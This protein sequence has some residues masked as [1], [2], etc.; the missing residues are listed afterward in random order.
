MI[1]LLLTILDFGLI[2]FTMYAAYESRVENEQ[3]AVTLFLLATAFHTALMYIILYLPRLKVIPLTYFGVAGLIGVLF[4][5]PRRPNAVALN[6]IRGYVLSDTSRPDER[7]TITNRY[8]LMEG[9]P[10]YE[11]YYAR[12]PELEE[13]DKTHRKLNRI[14]GNID[15]GYRPN[16]AMIDA[17]FSIPRH[18]KSIAFNEPSKDPYDISPEKA[19]MIAKNLARHLGAKVVGVCRVDPLCVYTNQRTDWSKTWITDGIEKD[20]PPYAF[21]IATEMSYTHVH[22]GPHTP[23]A[24]ETGN[25]YA[26]G[27]Y[28]STVMA[29]WFS[30]MG[31][32]GIAEHTG[33]YDVVLPPLAVQAGMGE[34]GRN[35]FLITSTLGSRVRLSAVMT[36]MP[37][38][39]DHPIDIAVE[40]FCENCKKCAHTCPSNSIPT[41]EKTE[42]NGTLRWKV[43]AESCSAYWNKVGTDCAICMAICPY[44][45]PDTLLHG[46]IR[47]LVNYSW[48]A[49]KVFPMI[50]DVLYGK[51]WKVKP[52]PEWLDWK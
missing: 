25:Q 10:K 31:Y 11:E 47:R 39:V 34:I 4:L 38:K 3:R 1:A 35:G 51:D 17:S 9:T 42:Y 37:L 46:I 49:P 12:H 19:T 13:I 45:R 28:I 7:D 32:T 20:Y 22:A 18:M 40:E 44:S 36:D 29:R 41:T 21:V 16:V 5:I 30:G 8:R 23:T 33:H 24:A 52:V 14:D 43:E 2:L 26:N 15:G 27:S 6:G 50:D 48:L